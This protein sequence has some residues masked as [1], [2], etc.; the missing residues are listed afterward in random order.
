MKPN[1]G[2]SPTKCPDISTLR[3]LR[4]GRNQ[5]TQPWT[6]A[7]ERKPPTNASPAPFMS[8]IVSGGTLRKSSDGFMAQFVLWLFLFPLFSKAMVS[9]ENVKDNYSHTHTIHI[10]PANLQMRSQLLV[11]FKNVSKRIHVHHKSLRTFWKHIRNK[12]LRLA[13]LQILLIPTT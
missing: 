9:R 6:I 10:T 7:C 3:T 5:T 4:M 2:S 12:G 11:G 13:S 8:T 1:P